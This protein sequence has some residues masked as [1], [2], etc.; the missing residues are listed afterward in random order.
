MCNE[1]QLRAS[2]S[3]IDA[4]FGRGGAVPLTWADAEP[5][6]AL[7]EPIRPTE[8]ACLIR[9]SDPAHPRAGLVGQA[10]RWWLVPGFHK[11]PVSDWKAMCT[12]ARIETVD[13]APTFKDAYLRQRALVP[14]TSFFEYDQPPGWKKGQ[15][16]R[17]WEI[18]WPE[19][20]ALGD[21]RFFAGIWAHSTPSDLTEPL[22][23]FAFITTPATA[24]L[25]AIHDRQPVVLTLEEGLAWLD[26]AGPGKAGLPLD[27]PPGSYQLD[28]RPR[29]AIMSRDM[30]RML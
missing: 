30:R 9:P 14:V 26:L 21:L 5:N 17:R 2:R 13:T 28:L 18:T 22:E 7:A 25:S 8:R 29:E 24:D 19:D 12:N 10:C 20:P 16:K 6:R 27:K 3:D 4:S 11:G 15:A 1:Y 23:S